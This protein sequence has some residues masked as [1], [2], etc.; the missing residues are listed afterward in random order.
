MAVTTAPAPA[1]DFEASD[2]QLRRTMGFQH[3]LFL[4]LGAIIGSGWLFAALASAAFAGP[5]AILSWIVGDVFVIFV[6][7]S[8]AEVAGM[9]PRSGAIVRYPHLTHGAFTGWILG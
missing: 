2:R 1:V 5:A 9:L 3:L 4:S 7:L 8:Y 6:S